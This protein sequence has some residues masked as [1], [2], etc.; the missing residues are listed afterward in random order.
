[1]KKK[2]PTSIA[3]MLEAETF[4]YEP[5]KKLKRLNGK[6]RAA[7]Y[8]RVSTLSEDQELSFDSQVS[9]Y[10][11]MI[12]RNPD[13]VLVGIYG[14]HGFS[15][16]DMS[17]RKEFQRMLADCEAGLIDIIY[18]KSISRFSRNAADGLAVMKRLKDLGICV[19]FEKEGLDSTDPTTEMVLNLYATMAQNESCS[20]SQNISWAYMRRAQMGNP[21]RSACFGYR[22]E[23]NPGDSFRHW[24]ICEDEAKIVRHIFTMAYQ[25]YTLCE[26][27]RTTPFGR[28]R[29]K[30]ILQNEAYRGDLLTHKSVQM[31]YVTKKTIQNYGQHEQVFIEEHHPPI[32]DPAV[33]DEV[34]Q[35]L[36]G[37]YLNANSPAQR[38]T[39]FAEHPEILA[40]RRNR[41]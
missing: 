18:V 32:V 7:A 35:Y 34:R 39:W 4:H 23:K 24:V 21:S 1:M 22:I 28:E 30:S 6:K 36:Q 16:L 12:G 5:P 8:C 25:G 13:L 27:M 37:G 17:R 41:A 33:F 38:K 10:T 14:D 20:L 19:L 11:E 9:Y 31:D 3:D 2:K 26:I 40:R 29:I 15:G